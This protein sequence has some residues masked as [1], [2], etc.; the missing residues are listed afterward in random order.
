MFRPFHNSG[1]FMIGDVKAY[2]TNIPTVTAELCAQVSAALGMVTGACVTITT[3]DGSKSLRRM[4]GDTPASSIRVLLP[5][6]V[7]VDNGSSICVDDAPALQETGVPPTEVGLRRFL[8]Q[9]LSYIKSTIVAGR[10][11]DIEQIFE[12]MDKIRF[13]DTTH[14]APP[15]SDKGSV[16]RLKALCERLGVTGASTKSL[17]TQLT[18]L[19][20]GW[21]TRKFQSQ[22]EAA[23]FMRGDASK[24]RGYAGL[25]RR[26]SDAPTV[27][28][29]ARDGIS[30]FGASFF[31]NP[32]LDCFLGL[33]TVVDYHKNNEQLL[34]HDLEALTAEDALTV[35]GGVGLALVVRKAACPDPFAVAVDKVFVGLYLGQPELL[36][37][38]RAGGITFPGTSEE[39]NGVVDLTNT[40]GGIAELH[41]G[42]T[43]RGI[44]CPPVPG[45]ILALAA[46]AYTCLL[47]QAYGGDS[48]LVAEVNANA[49]RHLLGA[50]R[51][52][53]GCSGYTV[54]VDAMLSPDPGAGFIGD[55]GC[56]T[57]L[58]PLMLLMCHDRFAVIR[59]DA[60]D[61]STFLSVL[62]SIY[63]FKVY[64][65][66]RD[67]VKFATPQL[68]KAMLHGVLGVDIAAFHK[69]APVGEPFAPDGWSVH[70]LGDDRAALKP[71][72]DYMSLYRSVFGFGSDAKFRTAFSDVFMRAAEASAVACVNGEKDR[73]KD[74]KTA[75]DISTD[76]LAL[77]L[78]DELTDKAYAADFADRMRAKRGVE[79]TMRVQMMVAELIHTGDREEFV[80][81]MR[82]HMASRE[83]PGY[84][85]LQAAVI[86]DDHVP[87]RA[88]KAWLLATGR[89]QAD[90]SLILMF[91]GNVYRGKE[92]SKFVRMVTEP[93]ALNDV[94]KTYGG[95]KYNGDIN[96]HGHD[97]NF[98]SF[99]ALG[100]TTMKHM[101]AAVSPEDYAAYVAKHTN[102]C[103]AR[104][105]SG[106][107]VKKAP[108]PAGVPPAAAAAAAAVDNQ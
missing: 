45:D 19:R 90:P 83:A 8:E 65:S 9:A 3:V 100:Y 48:G 35:V 94:A 43:M 104:D 31:T 61:P 105:G 103:G 64:T 81:I 102:C 60:A 34:L 4:P 29:T 13:Q 56:T 22:Q 79:E 82:A 38:I 11:G 14:D 72:P 5:A 92:W 6:D 1:V 26:L 28:E 86:G 66:Y 85:E 39:I 84:A 47:R 44:I 106:G 41:A 98:P 91:S 89:D 97:N 93:D 25:A 51:N 87:G 21:K 49:L 108:R 15:A 75:T 10:T 36:A 23:D 73:V 80:T 33:G 50:I 59:S 54:M 88:F 42:F 68:R 77:Q 16:A 70:P 74:G 53:S 46:A 2:D 99:F 78:L 18:E 95:H 37:S 63:A 69:V 58:K 17:L 12:F 40:S 20:A 32:S 96:R 76:E 62:K 27:D 55:N 30:K 57:D 7:I 67:A 101:Q 107:R 24:T 71:Q 52:A